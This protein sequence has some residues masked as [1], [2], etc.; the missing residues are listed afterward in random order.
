MPR[1]DRS[2]AHLLLFPAGAGYSM[3]MALKNKLALGKSAIVEQMFMPC[4]YAVM[5]LIILAA[6]LMTNRKILNRLH[7]IFGGV[8]IFSAMYMMVSRLVKNS[9]IARLGTMA[10]HYI[11]V[12]FI[13]GSIFVWEKLPVISILSKEL[14]PNSHWDFKIGYL[15]L[16]ISIYSTHTYSLHF[17]N[18]QLD[19]AIC[20]YG[21]FGCMSVFYI[22]NTIIGPFAERNKA[23]KKATIGLSL[24]SAAIYSLFLV[25]RLLSSDSRSM[26]VIYG[27]FAL[28]VIV[29]SAIFPLYDVLVLNHMEKEYAGME[30]CERKEIFTRI[31]LWASIGHAIAGLV[32]SYLYKTLVSNSHTPSSKEV[33]L[34]LFVVLI[35][36]VVASALCFVGIVHFS[37]EEKTDISSTLYKKK[38]STA[39]KT[40]GTE[41]VSKLDTSETIK[42]PKSLLRNSDFLFL[43]FVITSIGITRGISSHYLVTYLSVYFGVEFSKVTSI[44]CI[45][46]FSEMCILYYSKHLL[47]FFGYHWL[48]L[49]SLMAATMRDFNY[50]FLSKSYPILFATINEMF[51][52]ISSSCLVFSAVNIVDELAD[53]DSKAMAQTFYS[54]FYNGISILASSL[55]SIAIIRHFKDFRSLFHASSTFGLLCCCIV[56]IKYGI[57]DRKLQLRKRVDIK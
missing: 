46:T 47:K 4:N 34:G 19:L 20:D 13:C 31:R 41:D 3:C 42:K 24:V 6:I 21:Y 15:V 40:T 56:I 27:I 35:V 36:V 53:N 16:N 52:G 55:L 11:L 29:L 1:K 18:S 23:T 57:I 43:I 10:Q 17:F 14:S 7:K 44:L 22:A 38:A 5:S 45:R 8:F 54:G 49:F 2:G 26:L 33:P 9:I 51:K 32:I 12:Y 37:L 25:I 28:Y 50:A 30:V 48:L 39:E